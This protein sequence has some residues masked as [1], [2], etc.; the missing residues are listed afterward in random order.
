MDIRCIHCGILL[1][2]IMEEQII[3]IFLITH[4]TSLLTVILGIRFLTRWNAS[5]H[6]SMQIF[7][8][9][10]PHYHR[11]WTIAYQKCNL[12]LLL[13]VTHYYWS[14]ADFNDTPL[15]CGSSLQIKPLM[16]CK[17]KG[18]HNCEVWVLGYNVWFVV[19]SETD[20]SVG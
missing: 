10:F 17:C 8:G 13:P 18:M 9:F 14:I 15:S 7:S 2:C 16:C 20:F 11:V 19:Q 6:T 12:N 4:I 5:V 3:S 1:I